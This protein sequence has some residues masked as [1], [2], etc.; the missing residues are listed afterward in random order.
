MCQSIW[1]YLL[2]ETGGL[3]NDRRDTIR[4]NVGSRAS[5]FQVAVAL[6]SDMPGNANGSTTVCDTR[7]EIVDV[8]SLVTTSQPQIIVLAV[9]SNMLIVPLRQL[10]NGSFDGFHS[11]GLTH[12]LRAVVG[13]AAST[14]PVTLERF[15]VEGNDDAPLLGDT[16]EEVAGHP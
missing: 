15:G 10:L 4:V 2:I 11:S 13:V 16:D 8:A 5:V 9:N 12:S 6:C 1:P 7:A 3:D 14:V